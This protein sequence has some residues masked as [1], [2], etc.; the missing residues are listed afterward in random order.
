ME[1]PQ[2]ACIRE[3]WI[4]TCWIQR[5]KQE[6]GE[7][8]KGKSEKSEQ[9]VL[10]L[11]ADVIR[12]GLQAPKTSNNLT[13]LSCTSILWHNVVCKCKGRI[14]LRVDGIG[15]ESPVDS[16]SF[17][18]CLLLQRQWSQV[19]MFVHSLSWSLKP[20]W[21]GSQLG[22][23]LREWKRGWLVTISNGSQSSKSG[24]KMNIASYALLLQ[25]KATI[26][27]QDQKNT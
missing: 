7:W 4:A 18:S 10:L 23:P 3:T 14:K 1:A 13:H 11:V 27:N 16:S 9:L 17:D 19:R 2:G 15:T 21:G 12:P 25:Q 20:K 6:K 5:D 8:R 26:A 24:T 22:K